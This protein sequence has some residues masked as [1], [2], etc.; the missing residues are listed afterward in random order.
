MA[1]LRRLVVNTTD[2]KM[3]DFPKKLPLLVEQ[4]LELM[5]QSLL[6]KACRGSLVEI[7]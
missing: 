4:A 1:C 7:L 2:T 6:S 3:V 5:G